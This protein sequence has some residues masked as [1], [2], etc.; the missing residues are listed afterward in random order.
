[1]VLYLAVCV[2]SLAAAGLMIE[3]SVISTDIGHHAD[4][5]DYLRLALLVSALA[6]IGGALG[7]ALESDAAVREATYAY[8]HHTS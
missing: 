3:P 5:A 2:L 1:V 4:F 7:G 6:T 8:R